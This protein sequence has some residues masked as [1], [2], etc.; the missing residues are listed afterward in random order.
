MKVIL[1]TDLRAIGA[2]E[3]CSQSS[4]VELHVGTLFSLELDEDAG[5]EMLLW[6]RSIVS[7][8]ILDL[9]ATENGKENERR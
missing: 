7:P 8:D 3:D 1:H 9:Q 4:E 6:I 2:E 5:R